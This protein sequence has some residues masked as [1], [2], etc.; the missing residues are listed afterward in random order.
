MTAGEIK[1]K[2][3][4]GVKTIIY[5]R[6]L[7]V[8]L[9]FLLQFA[10][11]ISTFVFLRDYSILIFYIF[12]VLGILVVLHLFNSMDDPEFKL[13]WMLPIL[14]FPIFGALLYLWIAMQPG[15]PIIKKRLQ[16][17]TGETKP[18]VTQ[19][20]SVKEEL[21]KANPQIGHLC[22]YMYHYGNCPVYDKTEA[23]FY[24]LGDD[25]FEDILTELRK[26]EKFIFLEY[27]IVEE[28]FMWNSIL[29]VLKEKVKEGVEVRFM[30]DGMCVLALLP[31]FY[32]KLL[33]SE[34]I[35]CKMFSP[36]K[37]LFSSHYN[38]RDHRKILVIDGKVAFTGGTN[39]ADEYINKKV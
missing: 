7:F 20:A 13:V 26:A 1:Q 34:G 4:R 21:Q 6:T 2:G 16:R 39:L 33:Q 3:I 9:A 37:P 28:G 18:Y 30:Y 15:V 29:E 36:I 35:Q 11:I 5:G 14:I 12:V 32:P 22:D 27:F 19:E 38:N 31:Y 17:L 24:P 23:K 10:L 25:Q 8:V